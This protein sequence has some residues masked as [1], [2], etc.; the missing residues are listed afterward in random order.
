M[1]KLEIFNHTIDLDNAKQIID[2]L[3]PLIKEHGYTAAEINDQKPWGGYIR[4]ANS[5][6]AKFI[7]EF[8]PDQNIEI[9]VDASPKL[10]IVDRKQILSWQ[11]HARRAEIWHALTDNAAYEVSDTDD[12]PAPKPLNKGEFLFIKQG[13]RH[14]LLSSGEICVVA[15]IW[16]H[17]DPNSLSNE[18]DI[19]RVSDIYAR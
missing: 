18:D 6:T 3:V 1:N 7:D 12:E 14:R 10:L 9:K 15:E 19:T 16:V 4:L 11:W 8:F 2:E 5:D 13:E 17:T